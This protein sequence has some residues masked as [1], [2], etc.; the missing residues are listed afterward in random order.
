[1][2]KAE[3][4]VL[5]KMKIGR[6]YYQEDLHPDYLFLCRMCEKGYISEEIGAWSGETLY[7]LKRQYYCRYLNT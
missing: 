4:K 5:G 1:M 3:R 2:T 6:Y 7:F